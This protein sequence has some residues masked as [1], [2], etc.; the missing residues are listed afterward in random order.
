MIDLVDKRVT[1]NNNGLM[2]SYIYRDESSINNLLTG[3]FI[4][5]YEIKN[6]DDVKELHRDLKLARH[7]KTSYLL[8]QAH[9]FSTEIFNSLLKI[10]EEPN[11]NIFFFLQADST[12][13]IP[14]TILSR[15]WIIKSRVTES[16]EAIAPNFDNWHKIQKRDEAL[17][18]LTSLTHYYHSLLKKSHDFKKIATNLS[19]TD[20][21]Y[22]NIKS[23]GNVLLN[24]VYLTLN[25]NYMSSPTRSGIH[26]KNTGF[27]LS[28]E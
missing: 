14:A 3:F 28:R 20:T 9:L 12:K 1:R 22:K 21:T 18:L 26:T 7:Q 15:C 19:M 4:I 13:R 27:P 10:L 16:K 11:E 25:L 2:H 24:L 6:L 17:E 8:T 23:N 5:R